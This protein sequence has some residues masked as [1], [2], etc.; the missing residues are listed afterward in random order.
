MEVSGNALLNRFK[1]AFRVFGLRPL[2]LLRLPCFSFPLLACLLLWNGC[3]PKEPRADIVILNGAE[4]ESLDPAIITGQPDGRI[5]MSL[6]EGLM[7]LDPVTA[8]PIPALAEKWDISPDGK[9]YTFH[10]RT[11]AVW[12]T[13]GAITAEDVVYSWRRVANPETAADYAGQLF[14]VKNAEAINT[15][16]IKDLTQLGVQALDPY[17]LRVE[18]NSPTPFFLDLCAFRTLYVVPRHWIEKY[19]D[20]WLMERPLPTSGQYTLEAWRIHDK[21]RIRKNNRH[22]AA[23][24][25]KNELVDFLPIDSAASALNL[26]ETGQA[27]IIWDKGLV[28]N[29]LMDVLEKRPDCHRF[30][31][32]GIYFVRFNTTRK[33]FDDPRVRKALNLAIDKKR[34]VERITRAGEQPATTITPPGMANYAGPPGLGYNPE[35]A[36][37][38]LAEAGYPGGKGFP[39][40]RYHFNTAKQHEYIAVELQ[41]M[42]KQELGINME[43]KQTEWKVY[44]AAQ[45]VLDYDTMRSSWI[46]DYNDPNTFLDMFMSNNGNNRTGW[47]SEAYDELMRKANSTLDKKERARLMKAAETL[48]V[49]TDLPV[50]PLYYYVGINFY[51][52][53][54]VTGI[55][56]NLLDEHPVQTIQRV[57][58]PRPETKNR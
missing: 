6:F 55:Y 25:I 44:L 37:K 54:K 26:Y 39:S 13:G 43:L 14:F 8:T 46:G 32:L 7:Q 22:W 2:S 24:Q 35:L 47:K 58:K 31:Y 21:I 49:E 16:K 5:V 3:A 34:I 9:I 42:W 28:P 19:G 48:L 30:N 36:R 53:K 12:S 27:D 10:L 40:F 11:N 1:R 23:D 4:P 18:L 17:T 33:P 41:Q 52:A 51:D 57:D 50:A 56:P 15:G 20:R 38:L 45:S 29:D